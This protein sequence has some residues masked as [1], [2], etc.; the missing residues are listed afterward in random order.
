MREYY[1]TERLH[2]EIVEGPLY[3]LPAMTWTS[4]RN[5]ILFLALAGWI[6]AA[7]GF[8]ANRA[9]FHVSYLISFTY[10]ISILLGG[11]FFLMVQHLTGSAWSV[12]VR[13][14][15]EGIVF[16]MPVAAL[17]FLPVAFGLHSLYEW[18]HTEVVAADPVLS[19]KASYL[20]DRFFLIRAAI[21]LGLWSLWSWKLYRHSTKQDTSV[22][23]IEHMHGASRWSAPGL[24]MVILTG[25]LASFDWIMSLDPH[26]YST[27]FGLYVFSG[28]A[29]AFFALL[30]LVCLAFRKAGILRREITA[31][32][33]HDLGKW[34]FALTVFWAYIGFS[35]YM[36]IWYANIPEET[37]FYRHRLEGSWSAWSLLLLFGRFI[38]PFLILLPRAS[39]RTIS[40]LA[41]M[42]G[43]VLF[44]HFVDH[45]WL[46]A[47]NF[48]KHGVSLHWMDA[49]MLIAVASTLAFTFWWRLKR[50]SLVPV[51]DP[52]L[53]Q[54]LDFHNA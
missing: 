11:L 37:I 12:T 46:I 3:K 14:F 49:A 21:F 47:P 1:A 44:C 41:P 45:Y 16:T 33:Y 30:I 26:W 2:T 32:H 53:E 29:Q 25:T 38:L 34:L 51:R 40:I 42:A 17:L 52:R 50:H 9:Q 7:V 10:C 19:G 13:R 54:A 28:G 48:Q 4:G 35:Q 43:W 18:T 39:K 6:M 23:P 24:L 8:T 31:E 20:N 15:M 5:V 22:D 27:I 36:L